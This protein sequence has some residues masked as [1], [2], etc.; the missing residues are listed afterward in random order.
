MFYF[1]T[2]KKPYKTEKIIKNDINHKI[3]LSSLKASFETFTLRVNGL[4]EI[5][6]CN[7]QVPCNKLFLTTWELEWTV[8][9]ALD[10]VLLW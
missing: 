5:K 2:S 9:V 1:S 8:T 10:N 3:V 7:E 6:I 4:N